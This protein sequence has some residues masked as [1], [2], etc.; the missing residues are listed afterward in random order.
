MCELGI[1][2]TMKGYKKDNTFN[3]IVQPLAMRKIPDDNYGTLY[4]KKY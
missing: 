1:E 3:I 2:K 4:N